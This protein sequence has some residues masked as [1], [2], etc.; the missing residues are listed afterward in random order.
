MQQI[1]WDNLRYVLAV[2]SKGSISAAARDMGVNRSTVLRRIERFQQ[3]LN[4]RIFNR[5]PEGY[6]LTPEAEKM[7]AAAREV[8]STI[9]DMQRQVAGHELRLEGEIRVT[10]TDTFMLSL[11]AEPLASFRRHHAHI[12][13][14]LFITNQVLNLSR[15]D[16][17]IAIRPTKTPDEGFIARK[18]RDIHFAIYRP[19][20]MIESVAGDGK[21]S[22]IGVSGSLYQTAIGKWFDK[23][24]ASTRTT[25]RCD[26]FV[27]VRAC[28]ET[29]MGLAL[30]PTVLGDESPGLR[31]VDEPTNEL[32]TG[33]WLLIHPDLA[34]SA[35]I[36]AFVEHMTAE[37]QG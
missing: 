29:G 19:V 13:V 6:P 5:S 31:R 25:I 16:A 33:L 26:S 9:F 18:L 3:D 35:R 2:A 28:A 37:L 36:N 7:I 11:L 10:T 21:P 20:K 24:I 22:W 34:R 12:V 30:L 27:A 8:E 4:S 23:N 32:T 1:N 15:R 14:E 17:D